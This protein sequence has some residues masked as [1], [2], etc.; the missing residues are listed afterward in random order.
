MTTDDQLNESNILFLLN[1]NLE[2]TIVYNEF[3]LFTSE[4]S[5]VQI[6]NAFAAYLI[7]LIKYFISISNCLPLTK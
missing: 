5:S 2:D 7:F 3:T 4:L 6:P 1:L